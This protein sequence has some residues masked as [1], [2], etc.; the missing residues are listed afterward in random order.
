M[1]ASSFWSLNPLAVTLRSLGAYA[2]VNSRPR[3][4]LSMIPNRPPS[5]MLISCL[6]SSPLA[7]LTS[8]VVG[9][10]TPMFGAMLIRWAIN[11][12]ADAVSTTPPTN[13]TRATH[14]LLRIEPPVGC[15]GKGEPL[16]LQLDVDVHQY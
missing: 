10:Y 3:R 7:A 11:G 4:L 16:Q 8:S 14:A 13:K 2:P 9:M 5:V 1:L 6:N 15:K 12:C